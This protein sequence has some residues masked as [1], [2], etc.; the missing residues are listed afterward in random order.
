MNIA[1]WVVAS[2]LVIAFLASGAM[3]LTRPRQEL[4]APAAVLLVVSALV[5]WG[6]LRPCSA[7]RSLLRFARASESWDV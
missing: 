7:L 3:N 5:V 2:V 6:R 1:L 4:A